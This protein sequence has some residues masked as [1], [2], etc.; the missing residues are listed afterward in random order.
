MNNVVVSFH[1]LKPNA[2]AVAHCLKLFGV[3]EREMAFRVSVVCDRDL[4]RRRIMADDHARL[5]GEF[6]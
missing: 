2:L 5:T 1:C 3:Q 6:G 4:G